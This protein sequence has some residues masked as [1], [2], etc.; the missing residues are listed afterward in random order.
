MAVSKE[1]V[2]KKME[3]SVRTLCKL[4]NTLDGDSDFAHVS[5]CFGNKDR[6]IWKQQ[7]AM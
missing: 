7:T 6:T 2:L 4:S 1:K 5:D 3:A